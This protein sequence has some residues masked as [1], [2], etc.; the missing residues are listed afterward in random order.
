M[1]SANRSRYQQISLENAWWEIEPPTRCVAQGL[2]G[3][4]DQIVTPLSA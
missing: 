3:Q 1:T 2:T 4:Y